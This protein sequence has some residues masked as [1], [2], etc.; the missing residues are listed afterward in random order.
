MILN[1]NKLK[2][3]FLLV[4]VNHDILWLDVTVHDAEWVA[5]V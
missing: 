1:L 4:V 5:V 3:Y 2:K